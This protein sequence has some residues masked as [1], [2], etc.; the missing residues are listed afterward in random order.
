MTSWWPPAV[1]LAKNVTTRGGGG[2]HPLL[3]PQPNHL[4]GGGG[5]GEECG[6]SARLENSTH[7][8]PS[9]SSSR[10]VVSWQ[11]G[12]VQRTLRARGGCAAG[13]IDNMWTWNFCTRES[14]L[15]QWRREDRNSDCV[16]TVLFTKWYLYETIFSQSTGISFAIVSFIF[17]S[18]FTGSKL[19]PKTPF[20]EFM[21]IYV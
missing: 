7:D 11:A 5:G 1:R 6:D 18:W 15:W 8:A 21:W 12:A 20:P 19:R 17:A 14:G 13:N 2:I 10:S 3:H 16:K 4:P 9:S